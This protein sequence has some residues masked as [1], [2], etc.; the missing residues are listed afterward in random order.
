M[1][2]SAVFFCLSAL[3][4]CIFLFAACNQDTTSAACQGDHTPVTDSA[5][6]AT[7]LDTG[8]TEGSHCA[9]C[10]TVLVKQEVVPA[11]GHTAGEWIEQI[12]PT[13][14][15]QGSQYQA[16]TI[17][18]AVLAVEALAPKGHNTGEWTQTVAP[19]CTQ[20]G[21]E[22]AVCSVCALSATR[23]IAALPHTPGAWVTDVA[24][25]CATTGSKHQ[26]CTT[27]NAVLDADIIAKTN[28]FWFSWTTSV[29]VG[30]GSAGE[31]TRTCAR[32]LLYQ[33]KTVTALVHEPSDW[34]VDVTATCTE[35]GV[36]HKSCKHCDN[37]LAVEVVE[38]TGHDF[39]EWTTITPATCYR[40]G[41][42]GRV[43]A[44]CDV[45]ERH[46][47]PLVAHVA[48]DWV[49]DI[50]PSCLS[51]G[52]M[53]R[54]CTN[55]DVILET[56]EMD[57]TAHGAQRWEIIT[58]PT[59]TQNGISSLYCTL[60]KTV[61]ESTSNSLDHDVVLVNKTE[62]RT[63]SGYTLI[64]PAASGENEFF[65]A[66]ITQLQASLAAASGLS[67]PVQSDTATEGA[68]EILVG[69][70]TRAESLA[71]Y[72]A[73]QGRAFTIC[74]IGDK[75]VIVG[76][77]DA[78][79]LAALQ[80]FQNNYLDTDTVSDTLTLPVHA[81]ACHL[82]S[83]PLAGSNGTEF[84]FVSDDT[85][86]NDRQHMYVGDAYSIKNNGYANDSRDFPCLLMDEIISH[87]SK[88]SML[89][90]SHFTQIIDTNT[91]YANSYEFL[92]GEVNRTETNLFRAKLDGHEYG[93]WITGKKVVVT[94]HNDIALERAVEHFFA[95]Y[96]Y[97]LTHANG[98]LPQG[99]QYI[100]AV[101]D[102]GW[103]MDFPR[104][105]GNGIALYNSQNNNDSSLQLL[106][107]GSGV[108]PDAF[109]AYCT[110][111]E[112]AGYTLLTK[113]DNDTGTGNYFRT[114]QNT[115]TQHA[116]YVAYNA[117]AYEAVYKNAAR[118]GDHI[119]GSTPNSTYTS[120]PMLDYQQC[121]RIVSAPLSSA[122]LP[123]SS[124][125]HDTYN[126]ATQKIT[127]SSITAVR[128]YG[129]SVGMSYI[130]QLENGQFIIIDGGGNGNNDI[131]V[132]YATLT[133]L[134]TRAH[135]S[136]PTA[137]NPIHIAA[138]YITHSHSDHYGVTNAFL[139][140]YGKTGLIKMDYLVGN[141]PERSSMYSV[142]SDTTAMGGGKLIPNMQ[143]YINGGFTYVKVHTGQVL[144]FANLKME[145]LM[146]YED[147]NP[148][149]ITNSNDTNTM[150]KLTIR[151][152]NADTTWMILGDAC[153]YQSRWMCAMWGGSTYNTS[154]ALYDGSYLKADMVQLAHHGNIG[155]EIALYKTIQSRVVWFP[156]NTDQ[157]YK[158]V[159][160]SSGWPRNVDYFVV[161]S[162]S[163]VQ[164]VY[165][166]GAYVVS[167]GNPA[168]YHDTL[169]LEFTVNGPAYETSGKLWGIKY[170]AT[171]SAVISNISYK[172]T[173][174]LTTSPAYKKY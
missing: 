120:Y 87:V 128:L 77:D 47:L 153:I 158:Y 69:L 6:A 137:S 106:Y 154:T 37:I 110:R 22:R 113:N 121:L 68:K 156:H 14:T 65:S 16:C 81:G 99:Y 82:D 86:D 161:R 102:Q 90:A 2:K 36:R 74:L 146:T 7:C 112:Q 21:E 157:Y 173:W 76:S 83:T 151:S 123:T 95:L 142:G 49:T 45:G 89:P 130:I 143:S 32:C 12:A 79:T 124:L 35:A 171:N 23:E 19:T 85:W 27:C 170:R 63:L 119:Q 5:V 40:Q 162:L 174:A 44:N 20:K 163:T 42:E 25:T 9:V 52:A 136:A 96:D 1:R 71:A 55:C 97:A 94:A 138:W 164:Y 43:C 11:T 165:V 93:V 139:K 50:T 41:E 53:H 117:F 15:G 91:T 39:N 73:L 149:R 159:S 114:Y 62:T 67:F 61:T 31:Q 4:C 169:T 64:Y 78:L 38:A 72:A 66:N 8:L 60:C 75:I 126:R 127:E 54:P 155:C 145:V 160:S 152:Q 111:L 56:Q 131:A 29:P 167:S 140:Q 100:G 134:H 70:T 135:K 144:Y 18:N 98:V 104:P 129:S 108:N 3:L 26:S 24:A 17:C 57:A 59:A 13:C 107:T 103:I 148:N 51:K 33:S 109:L 105:E 34:I 80:Y 48:G 141:Y 84:R 147:H 101:D 10:N 132:L 168:A 150:S 30:C 88:Q 166:S 115:A 46:L 118:A 133:T 125:L 172:T 58:L 28:H 116:L 92:L 122:Y